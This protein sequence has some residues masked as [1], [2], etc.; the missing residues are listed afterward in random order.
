MQRLTGKVAVV[1]GAARGIGRGIAEAFAAEGAAV[2]TPDRL[3]AEPADAAA[4]K[5][6]LVCNV[7]DP[8]DVERAVRRV[9]ADLGR[10][11][12]LVN[13][14]GINHVCPFEQLTVED[15][16]RIISVDL[17][18]VFLMTR[19]CIEQF[20]GQGSGN[21]INIASVHTI[22]GVPGAAAYDAAK[23]GDLGMT[24]ALAIEYAARGLRFN[25]LSPGLIDTQIWRD[26]LASA[27]DQESC[28]AHWRA[29]I[30]A[31]RVGTVNEIAGVAVFL[32]SD[33]AAYVTGANIVADGGM[34]SQLI[35]RVL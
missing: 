21:L 7:G 9:I 24:R 22:A 14:A 6:S 19:A 23:C 28:L 35:S 1:T 8:V 12:V 2:A 11:D 30:P 27:A 18:G 5:L 33:D 13:C 29:N 26:V 20:L 31:G 32:A 16:D 25:C 3:S 15:W 17:R 34:T 4:A 10:I